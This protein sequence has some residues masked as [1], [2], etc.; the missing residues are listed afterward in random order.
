MPGAHGK[1]RP[2]SG[3]T[4]P[5]LQT[6]E[7]RSGAA[8]DELDEEG[9]TVHTSDTAACVG[10]YLPAGHS[11]HAADPIVVL[12]FPAA[13]PEHVLPSGL[14]YPILQTQASATLLPCGDCECW[15][16]L[17]HVST[18]SAPVFDEYVP[19]EQFVHVSGLVA[20]VAAENFPDSQCTHVECV[21][22]PV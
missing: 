20:P 4:V 10:E 11:V 16:Q 1:H 19:M 21:E 5:A 14:V 18:D 3:P 22:A 12:Y 9:Q 2:P 17:L 15:G 8:D 6:H 7:V 13:Q